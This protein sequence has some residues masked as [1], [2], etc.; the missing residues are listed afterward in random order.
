MSAANPTN[1]FG[2]YGAL[3]SLGGF[4][5]QPVLS[6]YEI[7]NPVSNVAIDRINLFVGLSGDIAET[8]AYDAH[9][10][11]SWS[12]GYYKS[13]QLLA[14]RVRASSNVTLDEAG[15]L[16]CADNS[17]PGCVPANLFTR[18][19]LLHGR[20]PAQLLNFLRKNIRGDTT[21]KTFQFSGH[22]TG[23]LFEMPSDEPIVVVLGVE[24][25]DEDIN[26]VPDP[27]AQINNIWG[28][29]T[30][31][32]TSGDDQ[33]LELFGELEIPLLKDAPL[34]EAF[35]VNAAGRWTDY[36]SYG[37]DTTYRLAVDWQ[38]LSWLRW[39][40]T[41]GT[42]FRAPDLFEQ[43][44]AARRVDVKRCQRACRRHGLA[45][46]ESV[47]QTGAFQAAGY[48]GARCVLA[49]QRPV[50]GGWPSEV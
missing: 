12:D 19:A 20:L 35:I 24:Y 34:A 9:V 4:A 17:I 16:V 27:D 25:R 41:R 8:W 23:T 43:F 50:A 31:G 3:A 6:S 32:I 49:E 29:T 47:R 48:E 22:V 28:T 44:L 42:S 46:R 21:Y 45:D 7:L 1:P 30:A 2:A 11:Y 18:D 33:V 36:N 5:V 14:D 10:G 39:R 26:D 15:N 13:Q 40:A 37:D 38:M